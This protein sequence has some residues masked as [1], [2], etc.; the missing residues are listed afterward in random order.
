MALFLQDSSSVVRELN[1]LAGNRLGAS[2]VSRKTQ[3][4]NKNPAVSSKA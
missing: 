1:V 2:S 4:Q 3:R